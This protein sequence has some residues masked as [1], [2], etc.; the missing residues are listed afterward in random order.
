MFIFNQI[1]QHQTNC[2][3]TVTCTQCNNLL[4]TMCRLK[5]SL[6]HVHVKLNNGRIK[7]NSFTKLLICLLQVPCQYL[8]AYGMMV[9]MVQ[10]HAYSRQYGTM[11]TM[12]QV[13]A[14]SRQYGT[15]ATMVQVH[16]YSRQYGTMA[17]M[18]QVHA[19]SRQYGTMATMVQVH[20]YSSHKDN[21][22]GQD[23][24]ISLE[25]YV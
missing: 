9:T 10:V 7:L 4:Y 8:Q 13:H 6:V 22:K 3:S 5:V 16:A 11:A 24:K 21:T 25:E 23:F 18:V 14:Y 19:Y 15:M 2:T 12:V 20:A 17:T 1:N